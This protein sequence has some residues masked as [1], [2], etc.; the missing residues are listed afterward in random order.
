M[1]GEAC[2]TVRFGTVHGTIFGGPFVKAP[3]GARRMVTVKMA[4]EISA[5]HDISIPTE[6]FNVPSMGDMNAGVLE[7]LALMADGNDLYVGCWGGIGRTGLFMAVMAKI[8]FAYHQQQVAPVAFVREKY[9]QHAVETAQQMRFVDDYD[10]TGAIKLLEDLQRGRTKVVV[11]EVTKEVY[12]DVVRNTLC[13]R[14]SGA[15][16]RTMKSILDKLS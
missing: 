3:R 2:I 10:V 13:E 8:M 1:A 4:K 14:V 5:P 16:S 12:R 15:V 11:K 7:A 9:N 6:D